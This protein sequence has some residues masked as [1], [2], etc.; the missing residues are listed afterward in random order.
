VVTANSVYNA[1]VGGALQVSVSQDMI[2]DG[3]VVS[4]AGQSGIYGRGTNRLRVT[5][6][7]CFNNN[8]SNGAANAGSGI[9][10]D[11]CDRASVMN[12]RAYDNQATPTQQ[13]GLYINNST[14]V[15]DIHNHLT[16][17]GT[18]ERAP[19][20]GTVTYDAM[21]PW[22]AIATLP[23]TTGYV[24]VVINGTTRKLATID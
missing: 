12:N 1:G 4:N 18:G 5:N 14:N 3:N 15:V 6:N 11:G 23:P 16:G 20:T 9:L 10:I 19:S 8:Q 17:N 2:V 21:Q 22:T 13:Y 7:V 24:S